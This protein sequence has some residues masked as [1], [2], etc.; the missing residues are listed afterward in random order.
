MLDRLFELRNI[1]D[2]RDVLK[3]RY[4]KISSPILDNR[5]L[6]PEICR[7]VKSE[8][9]K[10]KMGYDE[11][12]Y[13]VAIVVFIYSPSSFLKEKIK[14]GIRGELSKALNLSFTRISNIQ[15]IVRSWITIYTDFKKDLDYLYTVVISEVNN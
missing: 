3:R 6:I 2:T 14:T 11:D 13:A 7:I 12:F 10:R 4:D 9:L 8:C 5:K 1:Q 15:K